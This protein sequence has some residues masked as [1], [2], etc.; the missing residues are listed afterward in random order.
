MTIKTLQSIRSEENFTLFWQKVTTLAES[1]EV[2]EPQSP[3]S[4]KRPK[5]FETWEAEAEFSATV[6]DHYR[7]IYFEALDLIIACIKDRFDQPGYKVY[8]NLQDLLLKAVNKGDYKAELS[9]VVEFYGSEFDCPL[10]E[11]QLTVLSYNYAE[12]ASDSIMD[13]V[14]HLK[15][16]SPAQKSLLS[17]VFQLVKLILVMPATNAVSERTLSALHRVKTYL[18]STMSQARLNHLMLLCSSCRNCMTL[19][20]IQ[21]A[22]EF[23]S[24]SDHRNSIFGTFKQSDMRLPSLLP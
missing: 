1:V 17:Q 6:E 4:R 11:T 21:V 12:N 14:N 22:N 15:N 18:R 19:D 23:V 3:R 8:K 20:L 16:M 9:N 10:L 24:D 7:R 5:R 2:D 13:I